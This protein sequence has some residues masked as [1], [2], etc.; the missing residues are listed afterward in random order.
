M[1][2]CKPFIISGIQQKIRDSLVEIPYFV[3][4]INSLVINCNYLA[5][6]VSVVDFS[7][8]VTLHTS[9]LPLLMDAKI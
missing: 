4:V 6:D 3:N 5:V 7:T 8:T 2:S 9:Y 1:D